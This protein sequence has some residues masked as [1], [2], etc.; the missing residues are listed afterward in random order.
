MVSMTSQM[1]GRRIIM[2]LLLGWLVFQAGNDLVGYWDPALK[3]RLGGR[4]GKDGSHAEEKLATGLLTYAI[5]IG[6]AALALRLQRPIAAFGL[7]GTSYL[8]EAIRD[9]VFTVWEGGAFFDR[10]HLS[11]WFFLMYAL[12]MFGL[13]HK[14]HREREE[15]LELLEEHD[16]SGPPAP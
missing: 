8:V 5:G 1:R 3:V 14:E 11:P 13:A 12:M 9:Q 15:A 7:I 10:N 6:G 2:L 16:T 4:V